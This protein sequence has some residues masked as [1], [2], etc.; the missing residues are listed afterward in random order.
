MIQNGKQRKLLELLQKELSVS[1]ELKPDLSHRINK[2]D[3]VISF[4]ALSPKSAFQKAQ[5]LIMVTSP[6][7]STKIYQAVQEGNVYDV[8]DENSPMDYLVKRIKAV[9]ESC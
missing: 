2:T 8:I 9:V 4:D 6:Q 5:H 3:W 7:E 1:V